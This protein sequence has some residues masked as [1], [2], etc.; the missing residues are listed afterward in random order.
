MTNDHIPANDS[1]LILQLFSRN[2]AKSQVQ[3]RYVLVQMGGMVVSAL[4]MAVRAL[5][6]M[7]MP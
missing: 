4:L 3:H 6:A 5:G 1:N 7:H 2:S